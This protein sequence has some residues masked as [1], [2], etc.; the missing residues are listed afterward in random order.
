L[1][2]HQ[3]VYHKHAVILRG[4][5]RVSDLLGLKLLMVVKPPSG[6][7]ESNRSSIHPLID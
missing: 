7:E 1:P 2:T 3:L 5:K 6:F 4:Q